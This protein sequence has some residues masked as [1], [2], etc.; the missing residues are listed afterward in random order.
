MAQ[1]RNQARVQEEL[2]ARAKAA[3]ET[4]RGLQTQSRSSEAE[5]LKEKALLEQKI[6]FLEKAVEDAGEKEKARA[7][8]LLRV[9]RE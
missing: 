7:E 3:E 6:A 2:Q 1:G 9:K 8:E 5:F 4:V